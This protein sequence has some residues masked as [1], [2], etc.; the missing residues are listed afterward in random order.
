MV[1]SAARYARPLAPANGGQLALAIKRQAPKTP[2]ILLTG[3][4]EMIQASGHRPAGVD[5]V[6]PKP[7]SLADLQ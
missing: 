3:V 2:I 1:S 5:F 7:V 4:G 6:V